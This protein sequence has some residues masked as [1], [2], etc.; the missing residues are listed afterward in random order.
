MKVGVDYAQG[1]LYGRP[2]PLEGV[3]AGL[4][5]EGSAGG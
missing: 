4:E 5:G 3:L 1:W 2:A